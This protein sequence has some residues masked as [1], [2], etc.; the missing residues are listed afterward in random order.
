MTSADEE[1]Y[2]LTQTATRRFK[3]Y[4]IRFKK[5]KYSDE[6]VGK[7]VKLN[8]RP[9]SNQKNPNHVINNNRHGLASARHTSTTAARRTPNT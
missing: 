6:N 8:L 2:V 5:T 9:Q 7:H 3:K 4:K 1:T